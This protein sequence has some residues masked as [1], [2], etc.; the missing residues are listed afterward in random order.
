MDPTPLSLYFNSNI[1]SQFSS[2]LFSSTQPNSPLLLSYWLFTLLSPWD[3]TTQVQNGIER[4]S[5]FENH[6]DITSSQNR[7]SIY[8]SCWKPP[9]DHRLATSHNIQHNPLCD[10]REENICIVPW[11][12][13]HLN[14]SQVR[15]SLRENT[16]VTW[17]LILEFF[18][19]NTKHCMSFNTHSVH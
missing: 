10:S 14:V 15:Y 17:A 13:F 7:N 8:T 18:W 3:L 19:T 5:K 9:I 1:S 16:L 6:P 2:I 4:W 12:C 11:V